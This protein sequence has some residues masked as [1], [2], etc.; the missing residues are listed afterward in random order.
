M[1]GLKD[2]KELKMSKISARRN[3]MQTSSR[4][5]SKSNSNWHKKIAKNRG[6]SWRKNMLAG[7]R[8]AILNPSH[9]RL[10]RLKYDIHQAEIAK[11]INISESTFGAIERAKR[12]V[13]GGDAQKIA[14]A[15]NVAKEKIFRF[16]KH[17]KY[18]A[19]IVKSGI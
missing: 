8:D 17:D 5:A 10:L 16:V 4:T 6:E 19:I 15:L 12:M 9:V 7:R 3:K 11:K 1:Q 2:R 13:N 14:A 18:L